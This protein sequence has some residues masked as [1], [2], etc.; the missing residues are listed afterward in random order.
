MKEV[1]ITKSEELFIGIAKDEKFTAALNKYNVKCIFSN[2][3]IFHDVGE[4][5]LFHKNIY[6][7]MPVSKFQRMFIDYVNKNSKFNVKVMRH[8]NF[9]THN[10]N[11]WYNINGVKVSYNVFI[12]DFMKYDL[13]YIR[14]IHSII[15]EQED[16]I[17]IIMNNKN[18]KT[19]IDNGVLT[20][21]NAP[22]IFSPDALKKMAK[23]KVRKNSIAEDAE[24]VK[25]LLKT[26]NIK[27]D[28]GRLA[29]R[30]SHILSGNYTIHKLYNN[31][32]NDDIPES[33]IY[34]NGTAIGFYTRFGLLT[35][36]YN[37]DEMQ[38]YIKDNLELT[39]SEVSSVIFRR[40]KKM[41]TFRCLYLKSMRLL[42]T[43]E[44]EM[45]Y[46]IKPMYLKKGVN[47]EFS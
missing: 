37:L 25:E 23:D 44:L 4:I 20:K 21:E 7:R 32:Y 6:T 28:I 29:I 2:Y 11:M 45:T 33:A 30:K 42:P 24:I 19:L 9:N 22:Y 31:D 38:Q 14:L 39:K 8:M 16:T 13:P 1:Q 18:N 47:I 17:S 3:R 35:R 12:K 40:L 36:D 26:T 43:M 15:M 34:P 5:F 41:E 10:V 46:M 27:N